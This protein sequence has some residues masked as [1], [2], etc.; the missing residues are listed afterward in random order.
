MAKDRIRV[1]E[2]DFDSIKLNLKN[3]LKQQSEF[4]DYDFEGSGINILLD[5]LAYNTHYNSYYLNMIANE[6]FLDSS[7]LRNSVVSHA[8]K[9]G[10]T[11]RS[12]IAPKANVNIVVNGSSTGNATLILPKNHIFRSESVD[13]I[14]YDF[15]TL[16]ERTTTKTGVNFIFTG[17]EL[18]EGQLVTFSYTHDEDTNPK[19][20]FEI[21]DSNVDTTTLKVSV[22]QSSSNTYTTVYN[23]AENVLEV[24][25]QS[26][27]YFLQEGQNGKYQIYFGDDVLGR[28]IPD[29]SI[30]IMQYVS[31]SGGSSNKANSF[32]STSTI[33][34][35]ANINVSSVLA[36]YGGE[37]KE[38]IDKIKYSAPL[39]LLTQNRAVTKKDYIRLI[40]QNYNGFD[41][42]NVW[43]G[44]ENDP[45]V[46]GRVFISGKP[47]LGF[48]LSNTEKEY[49]T[50][51]VLK[52]ISMLT[53]IPE[54]K[55]I[56]YNYLK[57]NS[58]VYYNPTLTNLT[59]SDLKSGITTLIN[60][61]CTNNLNK[62]DSYFRLSTLTRDI[63]DYNQSIISNEMEVFVGKKFRPDLTTTRTYEEELDYGMPLKK[64]E[65]EVNLSSEPKFT[66]VDEFGVER[67]G[68]FF[69]ED[70]DSYGGV[71]S[72]IVTNPGINYTSTPTITIIGDGTGANAIATVV[73]G[74]ITRISVINPG[75]GYTSASV[76]ITRS[77][78]D[79]TGELATAK[80]ITEGR[81]GKIRIAYY[82][83]DGLKYIINAN[84][85]SGITGTIDYELGKI[86][87]DNFAPKSINEDSSSGSLS[88]YIKPRN[89][90]IR[91]N[92]NKML[93]LDSLDGSAVTVKV[94]RD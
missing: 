75:S 71:E 90:I 85:N 33:S 35:L 91:S 67:K 58:E 13:G 52:P 16:E 46:F 9:Y 45:P 78:P 81:Y 5:I 1:S 53:V 27:V 7:I 86:R 94:I 68:C 55:D 19:Q 30:V 62:F 31:T 42:V 50:E 77:S 41:D 36:A 63:D 47:K 6:S 2:L 14:S 74:K 17:V 40:K 21:P 20:I 43:G 32:L 70:P 10:Y 72:I 79:V 8:K 37:E 24:T 12:R 22:Q 83:G 29:G 48:E 49:I 23:K 93:V 51:E 57:L 38:S 59:E 73:N 92:F 26:N 84:T 56:S 64:G 3:F 25:D 61:Y 69:E 4:Q 18:T 28:K 89:N 54:I 65:R 39:K 66:V 82:S 76:Q 11:P 87:I 15:I 80:A 60:N 44:E 34:G 88:L